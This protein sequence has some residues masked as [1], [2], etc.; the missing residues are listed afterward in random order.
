MH[1]FTFHTK[2]TLEKSKLLRVLPST[3]C[4]VT[5]GTARRK[6]CE[7]VEREKEMLRHK[8]QLGNI[9]GVKLSHNVGGVKT[10]RK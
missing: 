8:M 7:K 1:C 2:K 6:P 3:L 9:G 10:N 4:D 5:K